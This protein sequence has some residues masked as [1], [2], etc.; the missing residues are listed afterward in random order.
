MDCLFC[1]IIAG[2]IVA[3]KIYEDDEVLAFNDIAA[4]APQHFL[5]IPKTHIATLNDANNEA[6]IGKLALTASKIAKQKGF[7]DDGFRVVIN[8]NQHGA[9]TVFHLHLHCL[10]GRQ[11]GWPP[12]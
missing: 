11:L 5:V 8:T 10:V 9:Q 7:A 3:D 12:G 6:L 1:K 2:D 4:Q